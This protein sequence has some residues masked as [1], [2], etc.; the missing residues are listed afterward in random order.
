M[1]I[2]NRWHADARR[3]GWRSG[4]ALT[5]SRVKSRAREVSCLVER[6]TNLYELARSLH[7][8]IYVR[9]WFPLEFLHVNARVNIV[10]EFSRSF[11]TNSFRWWAIDDE[12]D[13][14]RTDSFENSKS[15]RGRAVIFWFHEE[16]KGKEKEHDLSEVHGVSIDNGLTF[17][18]TIKMERIA[19]F[20]LLFPT[21]SIIDSRGWFDSRCQ[22]PR[23]IRNNWIYIP[24]WE[25]ILNF[26]IE[27]RYL[28]R[29]FLAWREIVNNPGNKSD[30]QYKRARFPLNVESLL[31]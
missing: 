18:L 14:G 6:L 9:V 1:L 3:T 21:I 12:F 10:N 16:R 17:N 11:V 27:Q 24:T 8:Y 7:S 25:T 15:I 28:L 20:W 30:D 2:G 29:E 31:S 4:C 26:L 5:G 13:R 19:R 22:L 23:A